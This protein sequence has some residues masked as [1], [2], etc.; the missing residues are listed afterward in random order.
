MTKAGV[1]IRMA[2]WKLAPLVPGAKLVA[3][4]PWGR[5][6]VRPP[7]GPGSRG[8]YIWRDYSPHER[9]TLDYMIRPGDIVWDVGAHVGALTAYCAQLTGRN[10][11]VEAFE[12][13]PATHRILQ[14]NT[15]SLPNVRTHDFALSDVFGRALLRGSTNASGH[16]FHNG[17]GPPVADVQIRRGRDLEGIAKPPDI[18]K[19][20]TEGH[21][22]HVLRGLGPHLGRARGVLVECHGPKMEV[23]VARYLHG[24]GYSLAY[25]RAPWSTA[26]TWIAAMVGTAARGGE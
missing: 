7:H 23:R 19:I 16:G 2:A 5:F 12:P 11:W 13:D 3:V 14:Q 17:Q 1:A 26:Q 20:D 9:A 6:R 15:R 21:E 8:L 25:V 22:L 18:I 24:H 4:T 10:G